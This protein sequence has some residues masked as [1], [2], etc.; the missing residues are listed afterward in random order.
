MG[1]KVEFEEVQHYLNRV[2]KCLPCHAIA[3]SQEG[4]DEYVKELQEKKLKNLNPVTRERMAEL[5]LCNSHDVMSKYDKFW[6]F[7]FEY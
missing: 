4:L 7:Q 6:Q 2:C 1:G 3:I 5:N